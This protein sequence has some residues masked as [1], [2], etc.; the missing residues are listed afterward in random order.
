MN[1]L[2]IIL[3]MSL[4]I[5]V[6]EPMKAEAKQKTTTQ[7]YGLSAE[8]KNIRVQAHHA[9]IRLLQVKDKK[10]EVKVQYQGSLE[11]EEEDSTLIISEDSF[12]DK[13]IALQTVKKKPRIT[14]WVPKLPVKIA[15]FGGKIEVDKFW[16]TDLFVFMF[17]KGVV[18]IK[19]TAGNLSVFQSAGDIKID[20]H[21]GNLT[22]QAEDAE[23]LLESCKGRINVHSFKGRLEVNKSSGHL[24]IKS[25]RSPLVFNQFTGQLEFRQEKGG[26]YLKPVIGSVSGYSKAG[27]IRGVI[28]PNE[29]DI[30]TETGKI[31]LNFPRS[32]SWVTAE[33]WEGRIFTPGYFHHIKTGGM[34]RSKGRLKGSKRKGNVSLKS[35][36]GSI[37][38]YQSVN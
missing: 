2:N 5:S 12:P 15:I 20:S 22:I 21:K 28:H 9:H 25:F 24:S 18:Q 19:N 17:G 11:M 1:R 26:V 27:E 36:S 7:R 3:M 14:I 29:V 38:V 10:N 34:D 31:H 32:Q 23:I 16:K 6:F 35:R 4:L 37:R 33:T 13:K 30:E 8:I